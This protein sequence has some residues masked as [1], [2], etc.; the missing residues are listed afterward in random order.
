MRLFATAGNHLHLAV[1]LCIVSIATA[2][3]VAATLGEE[4]L[5]E[6]GLA[7]VGATAQLRLGVGEIAI[8]PLARALCE[9]LAHLRLLERALSPAG[10]AT[11]QRGHRGGRMAPTKKT[12]QP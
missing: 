11:R 8:A 1:L 10:T 9:V 12:E 5:A 6:L 7:E 3:L 2:R 4:A